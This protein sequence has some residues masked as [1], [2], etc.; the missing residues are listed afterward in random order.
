M[1]LT[2][3]ARRLSRVKTGS[4][5]LSVRLFFYLFECLLKRNPHNP[6]G[7]FST[8]T[9][10]PWLHIVCVWGGVNTYRTPNTQ[11][12]LLLKPVLRCGS[13][14]CASMRLSDLFHAAAVMPWL[15]FRCPVVQLMS[16]SACLHRRLT[17][18]Q[19]K[20]S[21]VRV[22]IWADYKY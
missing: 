10:L 3:T 9:L 5:Y 4:S 8:T 19:G 12:F 2:P 21:K 7:N 1:T 17:V 22:N 16:V 13:V 15:T 11:V 18:A 20:K 14:F 6:I